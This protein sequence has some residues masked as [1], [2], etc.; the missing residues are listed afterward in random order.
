RF[1]FGG[2]KIASDPGPDRFER[3]ARDA[4][5]PPVI[6]AGV[7]QKRL[8]RS[9]EQARRITDTRHRLG[10]GADRTSQFLQ[11][12][13]VAGAAG[14]VVAAQQ[15]ALKLL[16]KHRSRRR[17]KRPEI[18]PQ[19]LDGLTIARHR[20]TPVVPNLTVNLLTALRLR[21]SYAK[22]REFNAINR[23]R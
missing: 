16:D 12:K 19:L 7:D 23:G 14:A 9:E 1:G 11:H 6:G 13:F 21:R 3:Y 22:H 18:F 8:E 2:N 4:A 17:L 20:R 5:D 15:I 10:V